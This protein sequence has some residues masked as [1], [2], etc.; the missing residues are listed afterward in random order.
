[1]E[2]SEKVKFGFR[3]KMY[4]LC[5]TKGE[6]AW[7][8]PFFGSKMPK[9]TSKLVKITSNIGKFTFDV[10]FPTS[11]VIQKLTNLGLKTPDLVT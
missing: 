9:T 3:A 1:M 10:V 2:T 4:Y 11:H 5:S 6:T 7:F 8:S